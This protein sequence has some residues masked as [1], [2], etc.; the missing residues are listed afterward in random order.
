MRYK[1][2]SVSTMHEEK[3]QL[4]IFVVEECDVVVT[5]TGEEGFFLVNVEQ[6]VPLILDPMLPVE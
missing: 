6:F 1:I 5:L 2:K 4:P 3:R